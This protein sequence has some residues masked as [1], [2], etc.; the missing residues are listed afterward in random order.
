MLGSM[1]RRAGSSVPARAAV[2]ADPDDRA[3]SVTTEACTTHTLV[4]VAGAIDAAHAPDLDDALRAAERDS[5]ALVLDLRDVDRSSAAG[6]GVVLAFEARARRDGFAAAIV[7]RAR[8]D[9][10]GAFELVG[11][12]HG[13]ALVR[14]VAGV[15]AHP[16]AAAA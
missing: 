6:V 16:A 12:V 7:R 13:G 5:E 3:L 15:V 10:P 9:R 1:E 8:G 14:A 11:H 4:R 2:G